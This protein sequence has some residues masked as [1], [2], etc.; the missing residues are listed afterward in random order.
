MARKKSDELLNMPFEAA[1]EKLETIVRQLEN[2]TLDLD[3]SLEMFQE[4]V[5]LSRYCQQKLT[6]A[7]AKIDLLVTGKNGKL[8][9][10]S[11]KSAE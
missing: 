7:E 8:D 5:A 9:L 10:K 2:E 1:L 11:A 6:E 3:K 4:G